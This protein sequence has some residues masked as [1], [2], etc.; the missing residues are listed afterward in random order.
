L[1][2]SSANDD[3]LDGGLGGD[4][5]VGYAGL[6]RESDSQ[7]RFAEGEDDGDGYD[8]D[9]DRW[10]ILY[11]PAEG[12]SPY[13]NDATVAPIIASVGGELRRVLQIADSDA[14]LRVRVQ[15]GQFG[16]LVTG[17]W[18]YLTPNKIQIWARWAYPA[19]DPVGTPS[20]EPKPVDNG[21][22]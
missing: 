10:D 8:N 6:D 22:R 18:R 21:S 3:W 5:L 7:N 19:D 1:S 15:N 2:V 20:G 13:A 11:E 16:N 17:V 9:Y 12:P 4:R 14:R